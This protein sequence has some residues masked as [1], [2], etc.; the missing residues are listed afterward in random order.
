MAQHLLKDICPGPLFQKMGCQPGHPDHP[1]AAGAQQCQNHHDLYP[2]HCIQNSERVQEFAGSIVFHALLQALMAVCL[3]GFWGSMMS[4]RVKSDMVKNGIGQRVMVRRNH[5]SALSVTGGA[6][7]PQE[8]T[9]FLYSKRDLKMQQE[10]LP[11]MHVFLLFGRN[12]YP[13]RYRVFLQG[14]QGVAGVGR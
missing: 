1:G 5:S 4:S 11:E 14:L 3:W 13:G 9:V 7:R 12:C 8:N 2:H 10:I 6:G